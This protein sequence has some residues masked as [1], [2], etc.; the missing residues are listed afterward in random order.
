MY[1]WE[2]RH[3][4][5]NYLA[6]LFLKCCNLFVIYYIYLYF[7]DYIKINYTTEWLVGIDDYKDSISLV[8]I[9]IEDNNDKKISQYYNLILDDYISLKFDILKNY[10][11]ITIEPYSK[12]SNNFHLITIKIKV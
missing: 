9:R 5:S 2:D 11:S 6:I 10:L 1:S 7:K 12:C 8:P 3:E 4:V